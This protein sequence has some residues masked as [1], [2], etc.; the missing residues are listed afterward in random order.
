MASRGLRPIRVLDPSPCDT[1]G[2]YTA[3]IDRL[4]RVLAD[5]GFDVTHLQARKLWEG[6]SDLATV[7]WAPM[8]PSDA[9]LYAA[10]R[11][12][13]VIVTPAPLPKG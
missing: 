13:F 9:T 8:P 2:Y 5:Y 7:G 11:A 12:L 6:A 3:D 1:L 4:V 10:V